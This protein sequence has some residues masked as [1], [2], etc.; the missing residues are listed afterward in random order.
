MDVPLIDQFEWLD[1][2]QFRRVE[3]V[4]EDLAKIWV[5]GATPDLLDVLREQL[6]EQFSKI[7]DRDSA[8][9]NLSR[10]V[11]ASRSPASLL[12]LFERDAEALPHLLQL[13]SASQSLASRLI[14]D[15]ESFDLLRASDGQP[16]ERRFL[17]DELVAEIDS[18]DR[19]DRAA[20]RIH[21]F[22][23]RETMRIAYGEF[24]RGLTPDKVGRQLAHVADAA[25]EASLR[26]AIKQLNNERGTP[27]LASGQEPQVTVIGLGNLGGEELGYGD[28]LRLVFLFDRIDYLNKSHRD[29]YASLVTRVISLLTY[30][31]PGGFAHSV[32][33]RDS[34]MF[35][36]GTLIC[37]VRDAARIYESSGQTWQRLNFV[38]A[39]TVAGDLAL[40]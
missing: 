5:C 28:P 21:N 39:R 37:S 11:S 20:V 19:A 35:E 27:K 22:V 33:S 23:N 25:I 8:V 30:D 32:D 18:V 6:T 15:P 7:D 13:F 38:K 17:I 31:E 16:T 1:P 29:Y 3:Q 4:R 2:K 9:S 34:P 12:A 26:F 36:T 14:A 24:V 10:F 40:G